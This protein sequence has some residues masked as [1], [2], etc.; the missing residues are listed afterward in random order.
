MSHSSRG[1]DDEDLAALASELETTLSDLR[2]ELAERERGDDRD[3]RVAT[4]GDRRPTADRRERRDRGR[5]P[6]RPPAPGELFRFTSDYTIP[7]V[8]AVLEAT[9]EALELLRGVIDLAAPGETPA[10]RRR[11]RGSRRTRRDA[12]GL[13]RSV[14]SDAVGEGVTAATDRAATDATDA[15]DRLRETL[16]EAD[17]PEDGE[18]R[19]LVADARE[20][21]A[22]LERRVRESREVVDRERDRERDADRTRPTDRR[23]DDGPVTIEVGDPDESTDDGDDASEGDPS[24]AGSDTNERDADGDDTRPE[25]DV[26]S[27]LESIKREMRDGD[28]GR[29][30]DGDDTDGTDTPVDGDGAGSDDTDGSVDRD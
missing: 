23:R 27:E 22:E 1:P 2:A 5:R 28:G 9:I 20:L 26:D 24:D 13:A 19:D 21:S 10:G 15:L 8:V 17:L 16:S 29:A 12:R 18:S 6:P 25:V 14:F 7:T 3:E 4:E 11:G 30:E